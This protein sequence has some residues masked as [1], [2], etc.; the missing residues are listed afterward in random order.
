MPE[1]LEILLARLRQDRALFLGGEEAARQGVILPILG[2]LGW[3]RDNI[4]E[5][6]PEFRVGNGRVDYCLRIGEKN[7][8][9]I[10]VKR[11]QEELDRHQ[12]QLLEYAFR[13]GIELAVLTN[14]LLWWLYLPLLRGSWSQRKFFTIDIERQEIQAVARHLKQFLGREAIADGSALQHART[15]HA[16]MERDRL[17]RQAI[18]DAWRQLCQDPDEQLLDL[19][20]DRVERLCGH[21]PDQQVLAEHLASATP[22][23]VQKPATPVSPAP[24]VHP[25]RSG[26]PRE[27]LG[28]DADWTRRKLVAFSFKT[29]HVET[30]T[31]KE[32]LIGLSEALA[33]AHGADFPR[34]GTLRGRKRVYFSE[35]PNR[36]FFPREIRGT[37]WYVETNLSANSIRDLCGDLVALFGYSKDQLQ[38]E[39]GER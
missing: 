13:E 17:V 3:D 1:Q 23:E 39:V 2:R 31:F 37:T 32:I 22:V 18:P 33:R 6:V 34:V 29:E 12:E 10:E 36:L 24:P 35:D 25:P 20:A 16:S 19:F 30:S 7:A 11:A 28:L 8:A 27:V 15:T 38:V 26:Q 5:V 4:R 21:R 9:F 14:G